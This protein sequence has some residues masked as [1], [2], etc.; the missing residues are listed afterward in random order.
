MI[1]ERAVT[2]HNI[3]G[4]VRVKTYPLMSEAVEIGTNRGWRR[5]HKHTD[6]PREFEI[7]AA[8]EQAIMEEICERFDFD[9][10][11]VQEQQDEHHESYQR[12]QP[13]PYLSTEHSS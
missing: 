12:K 6:E 7:C 1:G 4:M 13:Q 9:L 2:K 10:D 11:D 5:A 8:I 3:R